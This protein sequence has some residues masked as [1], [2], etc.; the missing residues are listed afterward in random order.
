MCEDAVMNAGYT[1][2]GGVDGSIRLLKNIMG[3]WIIQ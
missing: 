3:L 2:E 1:N